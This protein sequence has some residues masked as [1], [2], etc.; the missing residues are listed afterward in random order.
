MARP[1]YHIPGIVEELQEYSEQRGLDFH[2][3]SPYHLRIMDGGYVIVDL[4]TTGRYYVLMT[5]YVEMLPGQTTIERGGEKGSI[6]VNAD[7][8]W[9]FLDKIFYPKGVSYE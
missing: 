8:Y 2:Q 9:K 6:P 4:W 5:D 7:D 3:Y 1:K